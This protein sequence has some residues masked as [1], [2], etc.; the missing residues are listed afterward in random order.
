MSRSGAAGEL[1]PVDERL[2]EEPCIIE[3]Y[4]SIGQYGGSCT[5]GGLSVNLYHNDTQQIMGRPNWLRISKDLTHAVPLIMKDWNMSDDFKECTVYMRKGAKWSDGEPLT[6]A[7]IKYFYDDM[8]NNPE[9]TPLAAKDFTWGGEMMKLDIIDD[10]TFKLTWVA[11]HPSWVLVNMAT[12][13]AFGMT[14]SLCPATI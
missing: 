11:P 4:E 10:Y 6:T 5:V 12:C 3:P 13:T 7:D 14:T 8:L 9:I 1:P 2:P